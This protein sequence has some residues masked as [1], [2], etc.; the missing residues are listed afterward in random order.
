MGRVVDF[1]KRRKGGSR[2]ASLKHFAAIEGLSPQRSKP[3]TQRRRPAPLA[4][5]LIVG[6][7]GGAG[8]LAFQEPLS[9][10]WGPGAV[11]E[12]MVAAH[13]SLCDRPPHF[14]CVIDGDTFYLGDQSIRIADIDAPET[15]Q[16][17]C[18]EERRLGTRATNRLRV[19]LNA[20]PFELR[21]IGRDED[22]Y[23]RKLRGVL[24]DGRSLGDALVSEG[25]AR[26]WTGRRMPWCDEL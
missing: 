2:R 15:H 1:R 25:L 16:P 17:E 26:T 4:V 5:L 7:V 19:L 9:S 6:L 21:P 23:G 8:Y 14:N 20:G 18:Y 12:E 10:G 22:R 24:R 13:F 11:A 3:K